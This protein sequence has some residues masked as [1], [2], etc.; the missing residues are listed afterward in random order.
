M[1]VLNFNSAAVAP[2][3]GGLEVYP[4][5]WYTMTISETEI[6][7]TQNDKNAGFLACKATIM[8]GAHAGKPFTIR[9][10]LY[11]SN[12]QTVKIA[13]GALSKL[14]HCMGVVGHVTD[15]NMLHNRPFQTK[16]VVKTDKDDKSRTSN[17]ARDYRYANGAEFT[18]PGQAAPNGPSIAATPQPQAPAAGPVPTAP[19]GFGPGPGPAPAAPPAG[20]SPGSFAQPPQAQPGAFPAAPPAGPAPGAF[21]A[22]PQPGGFAP[23]A[24]GPPAFPGAPAPGAPAQAFPGAPPAQPGAF[25]AAPQAVPQGAPQPWGQPGYAPPQQ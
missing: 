15:T 21:P 3:A 13:E 19:P 25:P 22:A 24:G 14:C 2:V 20:P 16:L 17:D 23:V 11:N 7:E 5:G 8:E 4:E 6:K 12:P 1:A 9:F 10:N 18:A